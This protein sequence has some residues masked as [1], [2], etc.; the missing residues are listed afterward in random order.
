M[1]C[2]IGIAFHLL[3]NAIGGFGVG[4]RLFQFNAQG[5]VGIDVPRGQTVQS[6]VAI[7][8][9]PFESLW[10]WGRQTVNVIA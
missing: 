5:S 8:D 7:E 6:Q 3:S 10:R 1:V 9:P 2:S 4:A